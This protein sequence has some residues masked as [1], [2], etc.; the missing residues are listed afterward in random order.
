LAN[1]GGEGCQPER[2]SEETERWPR[3]LMR[4]KGLV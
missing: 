2:A 3:W 1:F 4:A